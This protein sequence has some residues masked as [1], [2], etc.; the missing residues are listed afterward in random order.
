MSM[1][2]RI[3]WRGATLKIPTAF[4][5][6]D[7]TNLDMTQAG[8]KGKLFVKKPSSSAPDTSLDTDLATDF[9]WENKVNGLG[10]WIRTKDETKT[11]AT[12][13]EDS[14][15][16]EEFIVDTLLSPDDAVRTGSVRY[17]CRDLRTGATP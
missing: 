14:V 5:N 16:V 3:V 1:R 10:Y 17:K 2:P 6:A 11:G 15:M 12:W 7:G 13:D 8:L 4:L 9:V